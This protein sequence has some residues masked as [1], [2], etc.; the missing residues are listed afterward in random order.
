MFNAIKKLFTYN[1]RRK[2][3]MLYATNKAM[4]DITPLIMRY[5]YANNL[6]ISYETVSKAVLELDME[7][8]MAL[9]RCVIN[10]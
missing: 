3:V 4:Q 5:V 8:I 9:A 10:F 7:N 2:Q 1:K 6:K